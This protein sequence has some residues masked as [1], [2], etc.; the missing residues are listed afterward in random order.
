MP[1][2]TKKTAEKFLADPK[3]VDLSKIS[4]VS[5]QLDSELLN[6]IV[7]IW[8]KRVL[9]DFKRTGFQGECKISSVKVRTRHWTAA[10][11]ADGA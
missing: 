8:R 4:K 5:E 10:L 7:L 2:L 1:S 11:A 6:K 9:E 3:S